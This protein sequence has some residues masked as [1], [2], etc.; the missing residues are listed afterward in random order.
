MNR[1]PTHPADDA[2]ALRRHVQHFVRRFGL[3]AAET[4]PC[5]E[6]LPVSYAHALMILHGG[7]LGEGPTMA[8]LSLTLGID[9]SNVTRLCRRMVDDGCLEILPCGRDAR[10]RAL[11]LTPR[12]RRRARQV[13]RSS[14]RR[15]ERVLSLVPRER[16]AELLRGLDVLSEAIERT[17]VEE[18]A[19]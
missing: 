2:V 14:R 15:F 3:L 19:S 8:E 7:E 13:D 1:E 16:R 4:T 12:G 10:A 6:S 11:R 5:G 17:L 18:V 9:K